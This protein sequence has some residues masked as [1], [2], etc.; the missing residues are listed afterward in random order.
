MVEKSLLRLRWTWG[1]LQTGMDEMDRRGGR[2]LWTRRDLRNCSL[3][4]YPASREMYLPSLEAL[5]QWEAQ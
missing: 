4:R 5:E 1:L 2:S 3:G